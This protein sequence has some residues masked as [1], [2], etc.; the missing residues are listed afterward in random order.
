MLPPSWQ[1]TFVSMGGYV[2][3]IILT[4]HRNIAVSPFANCIEVLQFSHLMTIPVCTTARSNASM[5]VLEPIDLVHPRSST[6]QVGCRDTSIF[7]S[8]FAQADRFRSI[9]RRSCSCNKSGGHPV[10]LTVRALSSQSVVSTTRQ[11][12]ASQLF[13]CGGGTNVCHCPGGPV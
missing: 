13:C 4:H 5:A 8:R 7:L 3:K 1:S 11:D 9:S 10:L 2:G 12:Q 6:Q